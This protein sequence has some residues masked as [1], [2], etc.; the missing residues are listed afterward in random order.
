MIRYALRCENRH[1]F[2]G[3]FRSSEGFETLKAAGQVAC[4]ACGSRRIEKALMA[5]AVPRDPPAGPASP[6]PSQPLS[7]PQTAAEAALDRLRRHV[8][9]NSDYVGVSFADEARAIHE[10]RAPHRAIHGEA[11]PDDARKLIED[12]VPVAPLPFIPRQKAN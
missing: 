7:Q 10:G 8:E 3:W 4:A 9:A 6:A 12:G 1:D 11:R 2:D 5:P